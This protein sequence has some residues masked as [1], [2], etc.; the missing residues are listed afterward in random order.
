MTSITN[1]SFAKNLPAGFVY[2]HE[3]DASI[4]QKLEFA[5][6]NNFVGAPLDGYEGI[7]VISTKEAAIALSKTQKDLK[8]IYPNYSLQVTDAYRPIRA[9]KHIQRWA[10]DLNDQKT[11]EEYYPDF[12][13]KEL[14]GKFLAAEKSS[15]SRGSTFDVVIID[16]T[17][18][19]WIDFGTIYFGDYA[20]INYEKLKKEQSEN[21]LL[22]RT[23]MIANGFKPYDA[24][25]WHFTLN[26]EP[27]PETYFDFKII[28]DHN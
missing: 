22:L 15:H 26:N 24:E 25:F 28:N 6:K 10:K 20:H 3:I 21:R 13:K 19:K 14:L 7:Q 8:K 17:T 5:S 27:F 23:L 1:F 16:E 12:D 4:Y 2:L 11:K 18:N 9:V